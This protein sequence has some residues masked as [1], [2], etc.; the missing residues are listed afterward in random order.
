MVGFNV[1]VIKTDQQNDIN[2]FVFKPGKKKRGDGGGCVGGEGGTYWYIQQNQQCL[3]MTAFTYFVCS[4][5]AP[6][7]KTVLMVVQGSE[8]CGKE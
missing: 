2:K 6:P 4:E 8:N 5:L 3:E 7:I 1:N